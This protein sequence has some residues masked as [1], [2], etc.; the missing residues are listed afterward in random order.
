VKYSAL[1]HI[2]VL[3]AFAPHTENSPLAIIA[4]AVAFLAAL[5]QTETIF[6]FVLAR[7]ARRA[8]TRAAGATFVLLPI[9]EGCKEHHSKRGRKDVHR[10][11]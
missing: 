9:A 3:H 2:Y 6:A 7:I 10:F 11:G 8:S 1:I 5:C 4:A